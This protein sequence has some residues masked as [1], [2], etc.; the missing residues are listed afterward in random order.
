MGSGLLSCGSC[1]PQISASIRIMRSS[2]RCEAQ[3]DRGCLLR[4]TT[5][6]REPLGIGDEHLVRGSGEESSPAIQY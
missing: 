2:K 3:K 1:G 6:V 5:D 4:R